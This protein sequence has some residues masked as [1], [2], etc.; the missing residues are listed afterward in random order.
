MDY[1]GVGLDI[2]YCIT[3]SDYQSHCSHELNSQ[4][5]NSFESTESSY[6]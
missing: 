6:V 4:N 2:F 1:T 3:F 5:Y